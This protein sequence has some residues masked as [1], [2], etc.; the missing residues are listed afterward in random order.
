MS[1]VTLSFVL[2]NGRI[3]TKSIAGGKLGPTPEEAMGDIHALLSICSVE[4]G[5]HF[6][7]KSE[8]VS[9]RQVTAGGVRYKT[10]KIIT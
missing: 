3:W 9:K 8:S 6:N 1:K 7:V 4:L 2:N 10:I 5:S